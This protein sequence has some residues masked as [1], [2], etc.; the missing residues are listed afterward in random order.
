[1]S[2]MAKQTHH[3]HTSRKDYR[4]LLD[5]LA[6]HEA[7]H[8]VA[9]GR[10]KPRMGAG[11][12]V[13]ADLEGA[14]GRLGPVDH[15]QLR[16]RDHRR[17]RHHRP[18]GRGDRVHALSGLD[19]LSVPA[20]VCLLV[21]PSAGGGRAR[22]VAPGVERRLRELGL[23][24]RR[25][26]TRDLEHA[27]ALALAG[28]ARRRDGGGAQR[29]RHGRRRRRRA[30]RGSR[31]RAGRAPGRSRQRSRAGARDLPGSA[32]GVHHDRAGS[33]ARDGRGRGERASRVRGDR[34]GGV[35]LRRQPHRQP[36]AHPGWA[37]WCTCTARCGR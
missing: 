2:P 30:A 23:E 32:A 15:D 16:G 17:V 37:T 10:V 4:R 35:R 26:D 18:S 20:P 11:R 3:K 34:L 14:P 29:R 6:E 22:K 1:M 25:E 9:T 12:P 24:V 19:A 36:S 28:S 27:R 31:R 21:N 8:R 7:V 13:A 33:H 5:T